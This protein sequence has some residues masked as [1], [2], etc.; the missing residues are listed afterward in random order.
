[1]SWG[2]RL[3]PES[4]DDGLPGGREP[5]ASGILRGVVIDGGSVDRAS[6]GPEALVHGLV[7]GKG[8]RDQPPATSRPLAQALRGALA[9]RDHRARQKI[10]V[11]ISK[12]RRVLAE[13]PPT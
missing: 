1:M 4:R 13:L 8:P 5:L 9:A 10:S 6:L 11:N 3:E 2:E 7:G 12:T